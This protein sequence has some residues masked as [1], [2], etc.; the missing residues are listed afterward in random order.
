MKSIAFLL[1]SLI[2]F[3]S[4]AQTESQMD[5]AWQHLE[6][7]NAATGESFTFADFAGKTVFVEPFATWCGNCRRQLT[8]V[9]AATGNLEN[10]DD[11]VIIAL[12][13]AE[14]A[15]D[16]VLAEYAEDHDFTDFI[17][18]SATPEVLS[19]LVEAFG[20]GVTNPPATPHFIINAEG[21]YGE[22]ETGFES[23]EEILEQLN[24]VIG[25]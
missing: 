1:L 16:A 19:S 6:L 17:F 9:R 10:A 15:S 21:G 14:N 25:S 7:S 22:L 12:S 11:V 5:V 3:L 24:A 23:G 18:A 2:T 20:R 8:N 4:F 13:V